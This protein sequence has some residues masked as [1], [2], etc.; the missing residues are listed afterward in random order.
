MLKGVKMIKKVVVSKDS[1]QMMIS[2]SDDFKVMHI[3]G[4]ALK[5]ILLNQTKDEQLNNTTTSLNGIGFAGYDAK[6]GCIAAKYYIK[7][8][9]LESWMVSAWTKKSKNG[10]SRITKYHAQL[11][12]VAIK[13]LEKNLTV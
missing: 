9:A 10:Y 1:L 12:R 7:H 2:N 8:N 4:R 6:G 3:I 13:N 5:V 11:N